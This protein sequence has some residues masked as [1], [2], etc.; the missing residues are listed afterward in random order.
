[1]ITQWQVAMNDDTLVFKQLEELKEMHRLLD[2]EIEHGM[3]DEMTRARKK[4]QKLQIR[5]Q[6]LAL[7]IELFPDV[8][9]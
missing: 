9:A 2:S 7:E 6:I 5:D 1:M 4:K 3:Y 8:P